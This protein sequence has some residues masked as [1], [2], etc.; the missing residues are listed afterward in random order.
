MDT[1][2]DQVRPFDFLTRNRDD[3]VSSV[4]TKAMFYAITGSGGNLV[5]YSPET[6][7]HFNE[8]VKAQYP[9][10]LG[11]LGNLFVSYLIQLP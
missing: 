5:W 11:A 1:N 4:S 8:N 3:V 7:H 9:G 2:V 6:F 10:Q